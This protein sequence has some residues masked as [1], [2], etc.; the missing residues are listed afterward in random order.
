MTN[1]ANNSQRRFCVAPMMDWTDRHDRYFLRRLSRHALLYTEMLTSGAVIHGERDKLLGFDEGELP[2]A[3]QLGGADP[4]D[5]AAA[6]KVGEDYG[7]REININVGCPSD[8]V[9]SG[10]FG[11]CLML[12]P[13]TVARCYETMAAAVSIPVTVKS[14]IGVDDHDGYEDLLGFVD[15]VAAAGCG[16]FIVH[17]R[18]A[19]L[20]GLSPAENRDIP[21]LRYDLV[22][23]LKHERPEL[24]VIING[25]LNSL[26]Q[27]A[28]HLEQV[29]GAMMGRTAYKDPFVLADVDERFY[30]AP[31]NAHSRH[32]IAEA[33]FDYIDREL[34]RGSRLPAITRH[35]LGLFNGQP[36]AR[37][38]R[39]YLS[40]NANRPGAGYEVVREALKLVPREPLSQTA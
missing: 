20:Q 13:E 6:A 22:H 36:G 29:D 9:Q 4:A 8:R 10:R 33:M 18:K 1:T 40:E 28:E 27:V 37:A 21:P 12:E 7:Y 30:G 35:M 26:D 11:A 38:W 17:A 23:R 19:H 34:T 3:L 2:T 16:T 39:R 31:A 14:R 5:M 15:I 24:E 25:G 32:D